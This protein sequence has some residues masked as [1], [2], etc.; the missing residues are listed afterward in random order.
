[1]IPFALHFKTDVSPSGRDCDDD[2]PFCGD[3]F[4]FQKDGRHSGKRLD[5]A[6]LIPSARFQGR[7]IIFDPADGVNRDGQSQG[8]EQVLSAFYQ[9]ADSDLFTKDDAGTD[10][11]GQSFTYFVV[12][13]REQNYRHLR[14]HAFQY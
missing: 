2:T 4:K 3:L 10:D 9:L 1:V 12:M 7:K 8:F 13:R 14:H 11:R 6:A 5:V